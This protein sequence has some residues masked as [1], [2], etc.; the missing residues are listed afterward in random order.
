MRWQQTRD[1]RIWSR[2]DGFTLIETL[3]ML[4]IT[5]VIIVGMAALIHDVARNFDK[6]T[7]GARDGERLLLAV[8]R[9]AQDFGSARFV[10][11]NAENGPAVAF[12]AEAANAAT[13]TKVVFVA[14]PGVMSGPPGDE[15]VTLTVEQDAREMRL[16]RR[17]APWTGSYMRLADATSEDPVV[18]IEGE[19]DIA[20]V[21]GRI[22]PNGALMWST[23]WVGQ[24]TLPRFARLI[25][26]DRA[27]G[28]DLLGEADFTI[29]VDAPAACG[30]PDANSG[31]LNSALSD[32][33]RPSGSGKTP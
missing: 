21:F 18:L 15:V 3:A 11:W 24:S 8:E 31:C 25:V 30:R 9:L 19:V 29:R 22:A 23:N 13:P 6:G 1:K 14:S 17:R 5:S 33:A 12:A 10:L 4:A 20:F 27:S 28:R 2:R 26:R 32:A 16:V 7:R